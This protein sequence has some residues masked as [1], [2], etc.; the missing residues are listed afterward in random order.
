MVLERFKLSCHLS[1]QL[2][3]APCHIQFNMKTHFCIKILGKQK[4]NRI[5][6]GN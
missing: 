2:Y 5:M 4:Y 1:Y 6:A 3:V